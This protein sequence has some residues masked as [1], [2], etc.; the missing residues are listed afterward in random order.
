MKYIVTATLMLAA[1]T[2]LGL[3]EAQAATRRHVLQPTSRKGWYTTTGEVQFKV[4]EEIQ[5]DATLPKEL[6]DNLTTREKAKADAAAKAEAEAAA[7]AEAEAQAKR[8][9]DEAEPDA[10]KKWD[11]SEEL[12]TEFGDDFEAYLSRVLEINAAQGS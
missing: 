3:T 8:L 10:R 7:R 4:G 6:A 2:V 11:K 1:G 5:C 9:R 12:R